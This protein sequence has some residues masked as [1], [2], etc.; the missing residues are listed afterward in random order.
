MPLRAL[1]VRRRS[2]SATG[3]P[4]HALSEYGI[5]VPPKDSEEGE[6][7]PQAVAE[8]A[9]MR[10]AAN[11]FAYRMALSLPTI[12]RGRTSWAACV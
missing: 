2:A 11:G 9:E 5:N 3:S 6:G 4:P 7:L 8:S 10:M 12:P 1:I